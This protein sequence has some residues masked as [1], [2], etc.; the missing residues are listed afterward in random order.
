[1]WLALIAV[2]FAQDGPAD[3]GNSIKQDA[4]D[5]GEKVKR[6]AKQAAEVIKRDTK[7]ASAAVA[8]GAKATGEAV[9]RDTK[10]A[11]EAIKK[12]AKEVGDAD[13][14]GR[15]RQG[16]R[17]RDA[18]DDARTIE[19]RSAPPTQPPASASSACGTQTTLFGGCKRYAGL[20]A[21]VAHSIN[22]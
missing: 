12:G 7:K 2:S 3:S 8:R 10:A 20:P 14:A 5:V 16:E 17:G 4:K 19:A 13:E 21:A 9:K 1:M 15:Q 11:G 22:Q 18:K 6:D